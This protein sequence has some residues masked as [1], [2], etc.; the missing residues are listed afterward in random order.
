M[1]QDGASAPNGDTLVLIAYSFDALAPGVSDSDD[2]PPVTFDLGALRDEPA[3]P[4]EIR[5]I[6]NNGNPYAEDL[7]LISLE[8]GT[9]ARELYRATP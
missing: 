4:P 6:V 3:R 9:P 7:F 8:R 1:W 2:H 5:P